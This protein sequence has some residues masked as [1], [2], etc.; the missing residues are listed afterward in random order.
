MSEKPV[1]DH[2]L[3]REV[4]IFLVRVASNIPNVKQAGKDSKC[5]RS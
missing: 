3:G 1:T 2:M 4:Q 5:Q